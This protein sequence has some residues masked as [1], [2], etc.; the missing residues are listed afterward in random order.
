M[1]GG[2]NLLY[3]QYYGGVAALDRGDRKAA[4]DALGKMVQLGYPTQLL[5]SAPEF[6]SLRQDPDF[7]KIVGEDQTVSR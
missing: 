3:V 2:A 7:K 4:L 5:R 1:A 6:R